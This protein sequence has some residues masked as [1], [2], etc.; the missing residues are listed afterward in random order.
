MLRDADLDHPV[1]DR[2]GGD[3]R[4]RDHADADA[5]VGDDLLEVLERADLQAGDELAVPGRVG[6][7]QRDDAEP[8]RGEA[9]VVGERV[10]EVADP[11]DDDRPVLG[12]PI[13]REIW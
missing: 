6:V 3:R 7:E 4:G 5:V 13:S 1:A 12:Q 9:G 2:L 8:A 10:A 11:D